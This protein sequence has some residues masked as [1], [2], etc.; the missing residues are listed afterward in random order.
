MKMKKVKTSALLMLPAL[1]L[2]AASLQAANMSP[3]WDDFHHRQRGAAAVSGTSLTGLADSLQAVDVS[4]VPVEHMP[5]T[6]TRSAPVARLAAATP[7]VAPT[8]DAGAPATDAASVTDAAAESREEQPAQVAASVDKDS[9]ASPAKNGMTISALITPRIF[10]FD[11]FKSADE[12]LPQYLER[13]DYRDGLAGDRRSGVDADIDLSLSMNDGNRD[14]FVIERQGFGRHNHR[15][16][17]RLDDDELTFFGSY[18]HYRSA[19]GGIDYLYSPDVVAREFPG[20]DTAT[21]PGPNPPNYFAGDLKFEPS[22]TTDY[23]IDRTRYAA[24]LE[25]KPSLLGGSVSVAVDY[26]GYQRE[27]NELAATVVM[28]GGGGAPT[29]DS[30][31]GINLAVDE[32]MNK[33]SFTLA[34]SPRKLFNVAYDV[35]LEKFTNQAPDLVRNDIMGTTGSNRQ[36]LS[37]FYFVPD[38]SLFSQNLSLS[39]NY[40]N[41]AVIAAGMGYSTLKDESSPERFTTGFGG[42]GGPDNWEGEINSG[43][44]YLTGNANIS[45]TVS[46]EAHVKHYNRDNDSSF[47][48]QHVIAPTGPN[49]RMSGPR[50]N[51]I[52]S[53]DYGVAADWRPGVMNSSVTLGWQRIDRERDLTY[54]TYTEAIPANRIFY[55]E[56]TLS[57]EVYLKWAATP[58][59]GVTL[60]INP[61]YIWADKTGLI[62]EPEEAVKLNAMA[63]Y[64]APGG[65]L[66]SGFYDYKNR[67]NNDLFVTGGVTGSGTQYN[68][69]IESTFHAAGATLNLLPHD[70]VNTSLSLYWMQN[71]LKNYFFTT[72]LVRQIQNPNIVFTNYGLSNYKVDS[73]VLS[74]GADWQTSERLKLSGSYTFTQNKGDTASGEVLLALQAATGTID[75][76][77]DNTLH[78]LSLGADY[79]LTPKATLRANYI[80]D[81]Y[82]DNAYDLLT[83]GVNMLAIGVSYAM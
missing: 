65:W 1:T 52:E 3:V 74:L 30:W 22:S 60:R 31:R 72:D 82:D 78:A 4:P 50:I 41:R 37:P 73:Y 55:R 46:V 24:G 42:D 51:S 64:A 35:S 38:T 63:S 70:A 59:P 7:A 67:K 9:A 2:L 8:A 26:E 13:Y 25:V 54:A 6:A 81:Y 53:M 77:L 57:D 83:G 21:Y 58:A 75:S 47:P 11:Y 17:A 62:T 56:D 23:H 66:L 16:M 48:V 27:G 20:A 19:T 39:K 14:V 69:D 68:Q 61:S 45:S 71:D 79:T 18:N 34:A 12:N 10:A 33:L 5:A 49:A 44:A 29:I 43:T 36:S 76:R 32:R 80:Y 15:G 40:G 28:V